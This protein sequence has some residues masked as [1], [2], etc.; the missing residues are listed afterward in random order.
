MSKRKISVIKFEL[1]DFIDHLSK[2]GLY[3]QLLTKSYRYISFVITIMKMK[4]KVKC[5]FLNFIKNA[6]E[7]LMANLSD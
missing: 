4:I 6:E 3:G 7:K 2:K 1:E 5:L